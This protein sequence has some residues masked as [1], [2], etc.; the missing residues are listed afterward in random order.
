MVQ[1]DMYCDD[2]SITKWLGEVVD[3]NDPDFDD[4]IR[5]RVFGKFDTLDTQDIPWATPGNMISGGSKSG[6]GS[7]SLPKIGSLVHVEF[8]NGDLYNPKW[9]S[10]VNISDELRSRI[11]N[12]DY[13]VNAQVLQY[14]SELKSFVYF[15]KH[16]KEGFVIRTK[17][18]SDDGSNQI[19]IKE[20][21]S[22]TIK[23]VSGDQII[24]SNGNIQ[25][26]ANQNIDIIAGKNSVTLDDSGINIDGE[27][28]F[29]NGKNQ[30][31]Y[32]KNPQSTAITDVSEIG[33]SNTVKV[34]G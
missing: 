16:P 33:V 17:S 14:D 6:G 22:I 30:V 1:D 34:G 26:V 29:I 13:Y 18:D 2:L 8:E 20:D 28:I 10:I 7:R 19:W 15:I 27:S 5:V 25:I 31:L 4:K 24:I 12:S 9:K 21:N 11:G 23:N 32:A 3:V